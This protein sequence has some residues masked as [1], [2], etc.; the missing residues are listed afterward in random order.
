MTLISGKGYRMIQMFTN[1]LIGESATFL[2]VLNTA[3]VIAATDV[4]VLITGSSGTGKELMAQAI[5]EA[6]PRATNAFVS[7]N[8]AALPEAIVE[9]ELFGHA[10][11]AFTGADKAYEGRI[12][13]AQSGTL[14]L[15]EIG[16][17]SLNIQAKLLRF[18]ESGECQAVGESSPRHV[19]VRVLAATNRD[20]YQLV[21]EGLFRE[22]LFYRL[23]IVPILMPAL[24]DRKGDIELL[25]GHL[26]DFLSTKH[27]LPVPRYQKDTMKVLRAYHWPGNVREL[28]NFCERMLILF[29]GRDVLPSNLPFEI[30]SPESRVKKRLFDFILPDN[31]ISLDE[32]ERQMIQQALG[33][34]EGNRSRAAKL[35][36][37]TRDT[38]LYRM[39]KYTI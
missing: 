10:K 15:D 3:S 31:G 34:T 9:S 26:T 11:G 38:L 32:L 21:Q 39:K 7:I 12:R 35:L 20:L 33:R 28:R 22:D 27:G 1:K 19:N 30:Q 4:T 5:H 23:N 24:Q 2:N 6:S 29:G 17:L 13:F 16:E 14:F 36:G 8:C 25:M 37:I 18:L